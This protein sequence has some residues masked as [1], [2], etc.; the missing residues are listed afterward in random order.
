M[1]VPMSRPM[2]GNPLEPGPGP[3]RLAQSQSFWGLPIESKC[4]LEIITDIYTHQS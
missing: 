4:I 2:E 3:L 1:H